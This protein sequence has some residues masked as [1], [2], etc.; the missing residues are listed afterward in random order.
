MHACVKPHLIRHIKYTITVISQYKTF[1]L[2]FWV[3]TRVSCNKNTKLWLAK[4]T[5]PLLFIEIETKRQNKHKCYV[6]SEEI[7]MKDHVLSCN[8]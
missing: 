8:L 7:L 6:L 1:E 5:Q 3:N 2:A 4:A